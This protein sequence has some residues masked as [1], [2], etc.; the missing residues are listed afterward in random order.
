VIVSD[1]DGGLIV[2]KH[3]ALVTGTLSTSSAFVNQI[4]CFVASARAIYS[5]VT[6]RS[7]HRLLFLGM[8]KD[9][10]IVEPKKVT[11]NALSSV[12]TISIVRV[13]VSF[14]SNF[15]C[16]RTRTGQF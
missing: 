15:R 2:A 6:R 11:A 9:H 7:H 13:G 5:A 3:G 16:I 8:L 14:Q 10:R 1:V 12:Q 4:Y